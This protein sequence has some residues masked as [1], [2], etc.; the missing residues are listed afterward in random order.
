MARP[1]RDT[2]NH[3][4]TTMAIRIT[5]AVSQRRSRGTVP[6]PIETVSDGRIGAMTRGSLPKRSTMSA[7]NASIRPAEATTF[8]RAGAV[9]RCLNTSTCTSRPRM[10]PVI[11]AMTIA[12]TVPIGSPRSKR[13]IGSTSVPSVRRSP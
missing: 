6:P 1:P 8:A 2:R 9:R 12:G 5:I 7:W 4:A 13:P 3:T 11:V 10:I